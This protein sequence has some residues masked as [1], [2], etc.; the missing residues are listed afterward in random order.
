MQL[1]DAARVRLGARARAHA[2]QNFSLVAM[3]RATLSVYD[4]LL[5]SSLSAA[6]A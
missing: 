4:E 3:Q 6:F 5:G 1:G 2:V